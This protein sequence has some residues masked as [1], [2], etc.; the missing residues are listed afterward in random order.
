[1][2][3]EPDTTINVNSQDLQALG[4]AGINKADIEQMLHALAT[5]LRSGNEAAVHDQANGLTAAEI[6]ILREGGAYG[7][8]DT[9]P[10]ALARSRRLA[11]MRLQLEFKQL[12][13]DSLYAS[14]VAELLGI[15]AARVRQLTNP[16]NPG[17][18]SFKGARSKAWFPRWQF[19]ESS[20]IPNLRLVLQTLSP[21]A[22]PVTVQQFMTQVNND[23][24]SSELEENLSPRDWLIAGYPAEP[25][26]SLIRD[27]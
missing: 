21:Q 19:V 23:L 10:G 13:R 25:V 18:Y 11:V 24:W 5:D 16:G 3:A 22:H 6:E 7:L 2:T 12:Q 26:L 20:V 9:S 14:A 8:D 15:S 4:N 17:L 27:I 1:M